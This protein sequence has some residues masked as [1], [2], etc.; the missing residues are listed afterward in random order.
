MSDVLNIA[1]QYID[2][3]HHFV[4]GDQCSASDY[5]DC[6]TKSENWKDNAAG[7]SK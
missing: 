2:M 7:W 3:S 4:G 5:A 6:M 1:Q